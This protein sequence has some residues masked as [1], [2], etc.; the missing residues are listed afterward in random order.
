MSSFSI[1]RYLANVSL[2]AAM[3]SDLVPKLGQVKQKLDV[4]LRAGK[5][6][7]NLLRLKPISFPHRPG[8]VQILGMASEALRRWKSSMVEV[9][10]TI[11]S[12]I[13]PKP[14]SQ[15]DGSVTGGQLLRYCTS[16]EIWSTALSQS[17]G[18]NLSDKRTSTRKDCSKRHL[19][20]KDNVVTKPPPSPHSGSP[21]TAA[22]LLLF[23]CSMEVEEK[24]GPAGVRR[25]FMICSQLITHL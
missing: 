9:R 13:V 5:K 10:N 15:R 4:E 20:T 12:P 25:P 16:V 7:P 3:M 2:G 8:T 24:R 14:S 11:L 23:I 6:G 18:R 19:R 22:T 1:S 17:Q 21:L